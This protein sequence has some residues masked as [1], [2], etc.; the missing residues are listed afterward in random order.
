MPSSACLSGSCCADGADTSSGVRGVPGVRGVRWGWCSSAEDAPRPVLRCPAPCPQ[1]GREICCMGENSPPS[2]V[3]FRK[4]PPSRK[5]SPGLYVTKS[6]DG[7]DIV[8]KRR[9]RRAARRLACRRAGGRLCWDSMSGFPSSVRS[10][11]RGPLSA[12]ASAVPS[13]LTRLRCTLI[14]PPD[15]PTGDPLR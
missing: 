11:T 1:R 3:D 6:A 12:S 7:A 4:V 14:R 5:L 15:R 8:K 9:S 10:R 2:D 13:A